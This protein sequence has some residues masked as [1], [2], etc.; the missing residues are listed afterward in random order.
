MNLK[1][2]ISFFA[3]SVNLVASMSCSFVSFIVVSLNV[4]DSLLLSITIYEIP[5]DLKQ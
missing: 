3:L 1:C 4:A 5:E 2:F